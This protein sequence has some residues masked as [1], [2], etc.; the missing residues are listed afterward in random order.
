ML[1]YTNKWTS[2]GIMCVQYIG[3]DQY[4]GG[5]SAHW[6]AIQSTLGTTVFIRGYYDVVS[7]AIL[8]TLGIAQYNGGKP[9]YF[10]R[11]LPIYSG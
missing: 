8:S 5:C 3:G 2:P 1:T 10:I 4:V 9:V 6:E 7:E 11:Y